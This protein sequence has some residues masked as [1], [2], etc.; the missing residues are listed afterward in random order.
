MVASHSCTAE[1]ILN[2]KE[3]ETFSKWC[4][5]TTLFTGT[6]FEGCNFLFGNAVMEIYLIRH[7]TPDIVK[8]T[9]YGQSDI[10]T[11]DSFVA[12]AACIKKHVPPQVQTVYSSPLRRCRQLATYLF[13]HQPILFDDRLMEIHCGHWEGQLWDDI[14]KSHL[15]HWMRDRLNQ[16]MPG[17]ESYV[18]LYGRVRHFF[19]SMPTHHSIAIVSHGGVIRSLLSY[20][21]NV[22][23]QDSFDTFAIRYGCVIKVEAHADG[24]RQHVL[25]NPP[26]EKEQHRPSYY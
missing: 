13:G 19:D 3:K 15:Q 2:Q 25:H 10:G 26:S 17:G 8:G 6:P 23:L 7:T 5:P 11:T 1:S 14:E 9:C 12:E 18:Q 21:N 20:I 4:L 22:S 16:C 24:W